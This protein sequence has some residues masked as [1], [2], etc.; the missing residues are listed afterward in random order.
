MQKLHNIYTVI[1]LKSKTAVII[2]HRDI[3]DLNESVVYD[4]IE[5]LI[6]QGYTEFLCGGM[7]QFDNLCTRC[8]NHLKQKYKA[9]RCY[10]VIP[11]LN[12]SISNHNYYDEIIYPEDFEKYH[13]KAA[14]MQ[15]NKYMV[16]KSLL[17]FCYVC[18]NFGGAIK[19]YNYAKIQGLAIVNLGTVK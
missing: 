7:G 13:Y 9:V 14:I 19:T 2:G 18:Y 12:T 17:A 16:D 5:K 1:K 15:R 3:Y 8:I 4:N 11:Y 10:L 6:K